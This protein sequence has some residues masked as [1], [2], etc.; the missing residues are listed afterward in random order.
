MT[1]HDRGSTA[2]L[3]RHVAMG[4]LLVVMVTLLV[5]AVAT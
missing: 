1:A 5:V 3:W 4:M 2:M